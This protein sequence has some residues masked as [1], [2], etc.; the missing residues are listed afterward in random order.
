[1]FMTDHRVH[2]TSLRTLI[3]GFSPA[4]AIAAS[5]LIRQGQPKLSIL[6]LAATSEQQTAARSLG[7][8]CEVAS[9]RREVGRHLKTVPSKVIIDVDDIDAEGL[10]RAARSLAPQAHILVRA[11]RPGSVDRLMKGG[12]SQIVCDGTLAGKMLAA[13]VVAASVAQKGRLS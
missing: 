10:V 11:Q 4:T 5:A 9:H 13:T 8:T 7:L 1:M 6:V 12:A 2:Q 3:I